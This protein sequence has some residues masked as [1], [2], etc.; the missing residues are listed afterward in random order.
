MINI[1]L[2][3]SPFLNES[4]ILKEA[5]SIADLVIFQEIHLVGISQM[6]LS[7]VENV[8]ENINIYRV[9]D[10]ARSSEGFINKII[11]TFSW[12]L[13]VYSKY[14]KAPLSC[15]NCH[16]VAMLPLSVLLKL[17]TGSKLVYDT[18][19][20]ETETNSLKGIRKKITKL[21]ERV[22]IRYVDFS[23]FVGKSIEDWYLNNYSLTNTAVIFNYPK[24]QKPV[25]SNHFRDSFPI[26][27]EQPI[28]LY[29]GV[30]ASGRGIEA[31]VHTFSQLQ[32]EACL[33]FMGYGSSV[34]WVKSQAD[35]T[36]NIFY[37]PAVPPSELLSYTAASDYGVSVIESTSVSYEYC[38]PNKLF[39]YIMAGKPVLVSPTMEQ[40]RFVD[41]YLIGEVSVSTQP[42]DLKVAI[43]NLL[44]QDRE[45]L[46]KNLAGAARIASWEVQEEL[47]GEIYV[48]KLGFKPLLN[49]GAIDDIGN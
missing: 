2:Y 24:S 6:G 41:E 1:H 31:L 19:E 35:H 40:K 34:E 16:S 18:H 38:M 8:A 32:G 30:I 47:F 20:L 3:P 21:T 7:P 12:S 15:I 37:H 28:F 14:Y 42:E 48:K 45:M 43:K 27:S 26:D 33:V 9:G 46:K 5:F 23:I 44:N 49:L 25:P 17:A 39:E 36:S 10:T 13:L 29:Q 4:R 22:L 11:K